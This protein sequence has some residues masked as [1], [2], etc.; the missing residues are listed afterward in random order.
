MK[1]LGIETSC[2]ETAISI[3]ETDVNALEISF[4][5]LAHNVLSQI[6]IH[7]EYGGVFL[8]VSPTGIPGSTD[9][10]LAW[11]ASYHEMENALLNYLYLNLYVNHKPVILYFHFMNS[12][13]QSKHFV[14]LAEDSSVQITDVKIN[15][16]NWKSFD[17]AERSLI[18][19]EGKDLKMEVTLSYE[20]KN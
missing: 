20:S 15:G 5:I 17:P 2:D 16:S 19:P 1:I 9:K 13:S 11:K 7:K 3:I 10:A 4:T 14:S 18:I 6:A 12:S 8:N